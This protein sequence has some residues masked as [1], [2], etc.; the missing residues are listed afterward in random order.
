M[1]QSQAGAQCFAQKHFE[2]ETF[3]LADD[4]FVSS[5]ISNQQYVP[6]HHLSPTHSQL[7]LL[8]T[9]ASASSA[10]AS[11]EW[12]TK[13]QFYLRVLLSVVSLQQE[14]LCFCS[15]VAASAWFVHFGCC[16]FSRLLL[17]DVFFVVLHANQTWQ[18]FLFKWNWWLI[19]T[20]SICA[21]TNI[22]FSINLS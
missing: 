14:F 7:P 18:V 12:S 16:R 11:T 10:S 3:R 20:F 22:K 9:S 6:L 15:S 17:S 1:H 13:I 21:L 4:Q 19:S 2:A 5:T 8:L